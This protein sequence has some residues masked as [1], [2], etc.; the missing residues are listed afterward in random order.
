MPWRK[1]WKTQASLIIWW[2]SAAKYA[3]QAK[4]PRASRGA[5]PSNNPEPPH[6]PHLIIALPH[7]GLATSGG[8]RN[9]RQDENGNTHTHLINP[10]TLQPVHN[11]IASLSVIA[12]TSMEADGLA[13][14]LTTLGAAD[15]LALARQEHLAICIIERRDGTLHTAYTDEFATFIQPK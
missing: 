13:T 14:G 12:R 10:R 7:H 15:A 3:A 2:K 4:A 5:S 6:H 8:Y 1:C 9:F 11:S